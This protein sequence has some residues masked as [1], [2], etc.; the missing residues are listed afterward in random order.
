MT[1]DTI[2]AFFSNVLGNDV[3]SDNHAT[4]VYAQRFIVDKK[5]VIGWIDFTKKFFNV[6]SYLP[7][8]FF[9]K[10]EQT[11]N[12]RVWWCVSVIQLLGVKISLR[13]KLNT[14]RGNSLLKWWVDY[15]NNCNSA[16]VQ[17]RD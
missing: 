7:F 13:C 5:S 1:R 17:E 10:N 8:L 12:G 15:V 11:Q 9:P 16:R 3:I 6:E 14:V 4:M 2:F